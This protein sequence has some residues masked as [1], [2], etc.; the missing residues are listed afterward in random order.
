MAG[1]ALLVSSV[2]HKSP[3]GVQSRQ[4]RERG[5]SRHQTPRPW[6]VNFSAGVRTARSKAP[7]PRPCRTDWLA[8]RSLWVLLKN[9]EFLFLKGSTQGQALPGLSCAADSVK[10]VHFLWV[11]VLA[12]GLL[13]AFRIVGAF[14]VSS[15]FLRL[16]AGVYILGHIRSRI[17]SSLSRR[18]F[19]F[20]ADKRFGHGSPKPLRP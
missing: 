11:L 14:R 17:N 16:P 6:R 9:S 8:L 10:Q 4:K 7:S 1:Q 2:P 3:H 18:G 12:S 20:S 15:G 5:G 19:A 13:S